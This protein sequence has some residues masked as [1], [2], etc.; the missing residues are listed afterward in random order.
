MSY[1]LDIG[2]EL[3]RDR[4]VFGVLMSNEIKKIY[5]IPSQIGIGENG[6]VI[7]TNAEDTGP[8]RIFER[9]ELGEDVS[10]VTDQNGA[11]YPLALFLSRSIEQIKTTIEHQIEEPVEI[12]SGYFSI[13]GS[14]SND[15]VRAIRYSATEAGFSNVKIERRPTLATRRALR[16]QENV[17]TVLSLVIG[18]GETDLALFRV[19]ESEMITIGRSSHPELGSREWS[20]SLSEA[21]L[22]Q[23]GAEQDALVEYPEQDLEALAQSVRHTTRGKIEESTESDGL[24]ITHTMGSGTKLVAGNHT[25]SDQVH[26]DRDIDV[27]LQ[28]EALDDY[29][30]ELLDQIQSLSEHTAVA[31]DEIDLVV[32]S[33]DGYSLEVIQQTIAD[34]VP[35]AVSMVEENSFKESVKTAGKLA[36]PE[37]AGLQTT[38]TIS[39]RIGL[40]GIGGSGLQ[41]EVITPILP[42]PTEA[43][44]FTLETVRP[45]QMRGRIDLEF[46]PPGSEVSNK[47]LSVLL[48][49]IPPSVDAERAE[50]PLRLEMNTTGLPNKEDISVT[51]DD[52]DLGESIQVTIA[53]EPDAN[54]TDYLLLP[55][56]DQPDLSQLDDADVEVEYAIKQTPLVDAVEHLE[57]ADIATAVHEVRSD[58]WNW[59]VSDGRSLDPSDIEILLRELDQRLSRSGVEFYVP[60]LGMEAQPGKHKIRKQEPAD[61]EEGAI[62]EVLK[63]GM[64][65]DGERAVP[66]IVSISNGESP[67]SAVEKET[68]DDTDSSSETDEEQITGENSDEASP[69]ESQATETD[70]D[71]NE[72][73]QDEKESADEPS[74][75]STS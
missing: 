2:V 28:Y 54:V 9:D 51:V 69:S 52:S 16:Q 37:A 35:D 23:V 30:R 7:G 58:L 43:Q 71:D 73:N 55:G 70:S 42:S 39:Y 18:A 31:P 72:G 62:I 38:E 44:L 17:E 61:A 3:D 45:N 34:A 12:G 11:E 4:T 27:D 5:E 66:A 36:Q 74:Q 67:E 57:G 63:P 14:A 75:D 25:L 59:G 40:R 47:I 15:T 26:I 64:E 21:L 6:I 60:E 33:G 20:T 13:P 50:I 46:L 10:T 41:R 1:T 53:D 48:T 32:G 19:D 29:L 8:H 22:E 56:Q 24:S 68:S 49:G 65:I